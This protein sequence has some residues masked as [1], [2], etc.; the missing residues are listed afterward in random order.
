MK[1]I[2]LI[3]ANG[4]VGTEL[5]TVLN[6][7]GNVQTLTRSTLD[8]TH[9][10]AIRQTIQ[11]IQPDI[12]VNSAA[13]TAVDKAEA[14]PELAY[15]I[16]AIAPTIVAETSQ[17]IN[18][19]LLHISTDYVFDG[20]KNTPYLEKDQTNPLSIYGKS[21]LE[22][23]LGIQS[24]GG[25]F[26]ILRTAWVY[27][28][29]G[30]GNFVKTMLRLGREKEQL[31]VV[32]DQVGS[33]TWSRDIAETIAELIKVEA[34]GIYHFTNSGVASWY[35]F[36]IAIFAEAKALGMPLKIEQILPITT[37]E[38]PTPAKRPAYSVLSGRKI[39]E[40]IEQCP[41]YWRNS[42]QKMLKDYTVALQD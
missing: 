26:C 36:A 18:A 13:Y 22:G 34:T 6:S 24:V 33:P 38:Y 39:T 30:Q 17:K 42:L 3:G 28:V 14:E 16:N 23:E 11:K 40:A 41:P 29:A 32:I 35:D 5:Q 4:Q 37:A 8:L 12:I 31:K 2:L 27:G 9:Q 25:K 1:Q 21:K 7:V 19:S 10:D 15:Q 20:T